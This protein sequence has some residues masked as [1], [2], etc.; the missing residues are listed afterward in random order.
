[1]SVSRGRVEV[2]SGGG[3]LAIL[4]A[5]DRWE[6]ED[7]A[8]PASAATAPAAPHRP[9]AAGVAPSRPAPEP[10][11]R[12]SQRPTAV[13]S[14]LFD[15]AW[16]SLRAGNARDAAET[17]GELERRA[18]GRAIQED[19]LYWRAVATARCKESA[20]AGR[21][22]REFLAKFPRSARRGE[23]AVALG[24]ILVDAGE[25]GEARGVFELAARDPAAS[26]RASAAEG[27][28]RTTRP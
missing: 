17:F 10:R 23:A 11:A 28:R 5:G 8:A 16:A 18:Q 15:S 24:W 27:I 21:L 25:F 2:R 7:A 22:F 14:A 6:Q 20:N 26:V 12:A 4:D 3:G 13:E 19:A 1:V 9:F